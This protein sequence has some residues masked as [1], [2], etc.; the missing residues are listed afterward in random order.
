MHELLTKTHDVLNNVASKEVHYTAGI[1]AYLFNSASRQHFET[2]ALQF[3]FLHN[4]KENVPPNEA[5]L[6][7]HI[8]W[9]LA[10]VLYLA[11]PSLHHLG[12]VA[13]SDKS[14]LPV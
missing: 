12:Q 11:C 6:Y 3:P 14:W 13:K 8:K 9:S 1:L 4:F 10:Q 7:V 2:W 5:C